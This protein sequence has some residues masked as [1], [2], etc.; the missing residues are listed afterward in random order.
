MWVRSNNVKRGCVKKLQHRFTLMCDPGYLFR[1]GRHYLIFDTW[2]TSPF[3]VILAHGI[4]SESEY[5]HFMA[6]SE[7]PVYQSV[8]N[9]WMGLY[10]AHESKKIADTQYCGKLRKKSEKEW[11]GFIHVV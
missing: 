6:Q 11:S 8:S 4:I 9:C 10:P 3:Y 5:R 1:P 7:I 2:I